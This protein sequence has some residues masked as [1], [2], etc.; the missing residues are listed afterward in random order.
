MEAALQCIDRFQ[1]SPSPKA[2]SYLVNGVLLKVLYLFQSSPSPKAGSYL[3]LFHIHTPII[4][5]SILS[6]PEGREL[7][8]P[9][10]GWQ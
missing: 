8:I 6:Q 4:C 5:V 7:R 2:G 10:N 3:N 9:Q 1:S